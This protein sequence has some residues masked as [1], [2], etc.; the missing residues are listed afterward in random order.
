[1]LDFVRFDEAVLKETDY[2]L[3]GLNFLTVIT[4]DNLGDLGKAFS[5]V[6]VVCKCF[7]N[8]ALLC[9]FR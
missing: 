3:T 8:S 5:D 4:L 9:F 6:L 2:G 1:M 7:E